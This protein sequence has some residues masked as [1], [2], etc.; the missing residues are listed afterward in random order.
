MRRFFQ[1]LKAERT[2]L[3]M[4]TLTF[5]IFSIIGYTNYQEIMQYLKQM[6]A[7]EQIQEAVDQ[8]DR[9][10]TFINAFLTLYVK[11]MV[12][13]FSMI[14]LGFFFGIIPLISLISNGL[15]LGVAL[16]SAAEVT[17]AHPFTLFMT[18]ILPHGI[19]EIPALIIAASLGIRF[20]VFII[21]G[22]IGIFSR[23]VMEENKKDWKE[24]RQHIGVLMISV[25]ILLFLAAMIESALVIYVK[26]L[27]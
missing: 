2:F 18:T 25:T 4:S 27:G 26:P 19:L 14:G 10:P 15:M 5:I 17:G 22:F 12:A 6:G 20:G 24:L 3:I 1:A 13:S 7:F 8:I 21:R 9:N 16:A 11:N 23:T